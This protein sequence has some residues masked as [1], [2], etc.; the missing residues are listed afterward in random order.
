MLKKIILI[1]LVTAALMFQGTA[2]WAD[3]DAIMDVDDNRAVFAPNPAA[4][5]TSTVRIL[6]Y[7]DDY[8]AILGSGTAATTASATFTTKEFTD[9]TG[10]YH[11]YVRWTAGNQLATSA[12]YYIRD[13]FGNSLG[14]CSK[15]QRFDGGAW[16]FCDEVTL[17]IGRKGVVYLTNQYNAGRFICADAVRFV[18]RSV[19]S[20][21]ITSVTSF[22]ITNEAGGDF[23]GGNQSTTLTA[24][25]VTV[26]SVTLVA[27][28]SG[29]VIVNASGYFDFD[30]TTGND[31]GR[32]SITTGTSVDFNYLIIAGEQTGNSVSYMPFA[33]TRGFNV[34][35]GSYT[36]RLVCDEFDGNVKAEDTNI[37]AVFVP[38]E[39]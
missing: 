31:V 7:G 23:S 12:R 3:D 5:I 29:K 14:S 4:W 37:T 24:T 8:E 39:Y 6:Y 28:S 13:N 20:S 2:L 11:V 35:S 25:D 22:D 38:T 17:N 21:D 19:D 27:P 36:F 16:Q 15:D 10:R 9:I 34:S 26:R 33:G 32:C 1:G 30:D 18:R